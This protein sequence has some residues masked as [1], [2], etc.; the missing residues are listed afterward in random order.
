MGNSKDF[1]DLS[2][3]TENPAVVTSST[4]AVIAGGNNGSPTPNNVL[5]WMEYVEIM[6]T[7]NSVDFGDFVGDE[8]YGNMGGM[9]TGHGG[10][11]SS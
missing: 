6:T 7:G 8:K 11:V 10:L 1:G 3:D 5:A 9:S 4:R 2:E